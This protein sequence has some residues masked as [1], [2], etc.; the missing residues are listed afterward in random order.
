[1]IRRCAER[2]RVLG[3]EL[4]RLRLERGLSV[5]DLARRVDMPRS[6]LSEVEHGRRSALF[7]VIAEALGVPASDVL[8]A[9][10]R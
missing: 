6:T 1:M 8:A 5:T 4:R 2:D 7:G 9:W 10:R 3:A